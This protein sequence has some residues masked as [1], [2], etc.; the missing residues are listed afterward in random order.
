MYA[1]Y[2][3]DSKHEMKANT[4]SPLDYIDTCIRQHSSGFFDL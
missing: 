2:L 4:V 3:E 1:M